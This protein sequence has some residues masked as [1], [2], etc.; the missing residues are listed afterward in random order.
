MVE[1]TRWFTPSGS[2]MSIM[3]EQS[4]EPTTKNGP[5]TKQKPE[6]LPPKPP[7][8]QFIPTPETGD[9]STLSTTLYK[10]DCQNVARNVHQLQLQD[11]HG[12]PQALRSFQHPQNRQRARQALRK[13]LPRVRPC[14]P[15][16][17]RRDAIG[18]RESWAC[19]TAEQ[20]VQIC[21][22]SCNC[23]E[24]SEWTSLSPA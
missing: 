10:T 12:H 19:A 2:I 3:K 8:T 7:Q 15:P 1:S 14:R 22:C 6:N 16:P 4:L 17:P 24:R 13:R 21:T 11:Q 5:N 18:F 20:P 23:A 9:Q